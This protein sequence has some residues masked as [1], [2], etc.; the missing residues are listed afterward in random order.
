MTPTNATPM[1]V[2]LVSEHA[3][4]LAL[5][6]GVDAGGQNVHVAAL[7]EALAALGAEVVVHT[8]RD[9][10][11]LPRRVR[12]APGVVVDHVDAGPPEPIPK[13]ALARWMDA[14]ADDLADQWATDRPDVVHAHFWMSGIAAVEAG[15]R[16]PV[17]VALTYHAL[18]AEKRRHQ[19]RADT[20][21]PGRV[22]V[23]AW[24]ARAVDRVVATTAHEARAVASMGALDADV[25]IVPCGVDLERFQ[26]PGRRL[27]P[28]AGRTR[29]ACISRLVPRKGT[30]DVIRALVDLPDAEL[31]VAGGPPQAMLHED[32]EAEA[33]RHLAEEVGVA[34]RM[35]FLG[36]VDRADVPALL[37]SVDVVCCCP[38]YEPFGLVA[39]EAMACGVPVVAT[40]VGGLAE[41]VIDGRTGALV[42]PHDPA[43]IAAA[44]R[45]VVG[46]ERR[47]RLAEAACARAR[48]YAW[49]RI[50][51]RT[52]AV[53]EQ[54]VAAGRRHCTEPIP[55]W[56]GAPADELVGGTW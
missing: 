29:V 19:G 4:P 8:R 56:Y 32:R 9:D 52:A 43:A 46:D 21:P 53:Y 5:L 18:G 20:S 28:P 1:K 6:G 51:A 30:A 34:D 49:P 13:D 2:S 26:A 31:L 35:R 7:A 40:R 10:P 22:A 15:D 16:A 54:M 23:E 42:P 39:V 11:A 50:A 47:A 27:L 44:V 55:P 33:L 38:W 37:R 3:S 17:P 48:A 12:F 36:A 41:T 24:L 14:F 45:W 25:S